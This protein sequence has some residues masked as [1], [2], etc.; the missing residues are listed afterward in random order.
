[1]SEELYR[2]Q[3]HISV[4]QLFEGINTNSDIR[5]VF[6]DYF[7]SSTGKTF[8]KI[9]QVKVNEQ[10][11]GQSHGQA[12]DLLKVFEIAQGINVWLNCGR[13]LRTIRLSLTQKELHCLDIESKLNKFIN[14]QGQEI[15]YHKIHFKR[16][17]QNDAIKKMMN[18]LE[19]EL[20]E[21][22]IEQVNTLAERAYARETVTCDEE[23]LDADAI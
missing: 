1:M 5:V 11:S 22:E 6:N 7:T 9:L 20:A 16:V 13:Q 12:I 4:T 3:S 2:Q 8:V 18:K 19:K 15:A 21:K 17:T 10:S 23:E 14:N